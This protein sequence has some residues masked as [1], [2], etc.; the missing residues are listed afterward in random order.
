[1]DACSSMP[2]RGLAGPNARLSTSC[3]RVSQRRSLRDT[4]R[5]V[6]KAEVMRLTQELRGASTGAKGGAA[7]AERLKKELEKTRCGLR[8]S[9]FSL[10]L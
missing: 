7:A 1:M 8:P 10:G 3:F 5:R 9:T 2:G 6:H 4:C